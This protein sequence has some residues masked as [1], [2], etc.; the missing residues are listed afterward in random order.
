MIAFQCILYANNSRMKLTKIPQSSPKRHPIKFGIGNFCQS[1]FQSRI[2]IKPASKA[3]IKEPK[4]EQRGVKESGDLAKDN[5]FN[6]NNLKERLDS[7]VYPM[8]IVLFFNVLLIKK[9]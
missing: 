3:P 9:G 5:R 2:T 4:R 1:S 7:I 8:V 6:S